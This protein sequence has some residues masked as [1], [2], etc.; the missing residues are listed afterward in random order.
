MNDYGTTFRN[1]D[2]KESERQKN[3]DAFYKENHEKQS[4]AF[5]QKQREE[6]LKLD[7]DVMSIWDAAELLNELI[8][9]SDPDLDLPQIEH[10]LQTAEGCRSM[11]PDAEYDWFHL[12][13]FIHD[14]GKVMSHK[15]FGELPQWAVV[16]DTF[17]VG[18][19]Y[20]KGIILSKYF[21]DNA[22]F[23]KPEY[24]S[25]CGVYAK[26]CGLDNVVMSWGHD[27]YMYQVMK[28]NGCTLPLAAQYI[29]RYHSFY[30]WHTANAYDHLCN[31]TDREMLFWVREF[32]KNDLYSKSTKTIDIGELKEYYTRL[33][34]KYFP[35]K[36][37]W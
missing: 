18:C 21:E 29:V 26:N 17:P 23:N 28:L 3:V 24:R 36:L 31:E 27:E 37:R 15:K 10:L 14:L 5:V 1:Y 13:G 12:T 8:D 16:G 32:N 11:Y 19:A 9:E 6:W 25:K 34:N 30:A 20:D 2:D 4:Y 35:A 22:D 33:I 7:K